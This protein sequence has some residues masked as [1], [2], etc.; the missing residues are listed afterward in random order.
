MHRPGSGASGERSRPARKTNAPATGVG[1]K[2]IRDWRAAIVLGLL[3]SLLAPAFAGGPSKTPVVAT[4]PPGAAIAS[5][6]ALATEAGLQ[7]LRAGGNAFDAAIA[8]SSTLSVVEPVSSGLGGGGF[9][10]LHDA[11]NG[12][13]VMIDAREV[14][15]ASATPSFH[16]YAKGGLGLDKAENGAASAGIHGLPA[17]LVHLQKKYGRLP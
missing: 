2:Q 6:H 11:K 8:V 3:F 14:A 16:L 5:G 13:D 12:R 9:F 7:I 17:G 4:H 1:L 10:L 15:P